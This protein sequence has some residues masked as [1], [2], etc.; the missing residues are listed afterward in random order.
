MFIRLLCV[1]P[2]WKLCRGN[3]QVVR[4]NSATVLYR[5]RPYVCSGYLLCSLRPA[6]PENLTVVEPK[7]D[8]EARSC[9]ERPEEVTQTPPWAPCWHW[10]ADARRLK[11]LSGIR[12]DASQPSPRSRQSFRGRAARFA[13]PVDGSHAGLCAD[14]GPLHDRRSQPREL[15]CA[16]FA[17]LRSSVAGIECPRPWDSAL[18]SR[19]ARKASSTERLLSA[20]PASALPEPPHADIRS[21]HPSASACPVVLDS[22]V[23]VLGHWPWILKF[24]RTWTRDGP[25]DEPGRGVARKIPNRQGCDR[26]MRV[27]QSRFSYSQLTSSPRFTRRY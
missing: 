27:A 17:V 6:L 20:A 7:R 1:H 3:E 23:R 2:S 15:T 4:S 5:T 26:R 9:T 13:R 11:R 21:A 16:E 12:G 18:T 22:L 8:G 10:Q 24:E 14:Q 25:D 19:Y